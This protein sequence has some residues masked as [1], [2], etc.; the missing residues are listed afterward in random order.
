MNFLF[1]SSENLFFG[2]FVVC[3]LVR[4]MLQHRVSLEVFNSIFNRSKVSFISISVD[5]ASV[6]LCSNTMNK[7]CR[8]RKK[9]AIRINCAFDVIIAGKVRF[10]GSERA[11]KEIYDLEESEMNVE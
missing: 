8:G 7:S 1:Q 9:G 11:R 10:T 5:T 2:N 4:V 3:V 6:S